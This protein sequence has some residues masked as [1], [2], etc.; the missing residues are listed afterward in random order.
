MTKARIGMVLDEWTSANPNCRFPGS[1][2]G[3]GTLSY[4]ASYGGYAA[5][6]QLPGTSHRGVR[7]RTLAA[8]LAAAALAVAAPPPLRLP[9]PITASVTRAASQASPCAA[10]A[11]STPAPES[12]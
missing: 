1:S 8:A 2:V 11:R 9:A 7:L 10:E 3:I 5:N 6:R 12:L 4:S